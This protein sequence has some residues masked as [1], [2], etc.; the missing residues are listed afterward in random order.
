MVEKLGGW[1]LA[2]LITACLAIVGTLYL[3]IMNGSLLAAAIAGFLFA[4][5]FNAIVGSGVLGVLSFAYNQEDKREK[6]R[7][8]QFILNTQENLAMMAS[9]SKAQAEQAKAQAANQRAMFEEMRFKQLTSGKPSE[10][11]E[12]EFDEDFNPAW[13]NILETGFNGNT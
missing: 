12:G 13:L 9:T 10:I 8:E 3:G 7:Q 4:Q 6:R 11:S 2:I 1:L 5:V